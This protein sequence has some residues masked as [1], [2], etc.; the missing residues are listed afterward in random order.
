MTADEA[1]PDPS[2]DLINGHALREN[3][4]LDRSA[5]LLR[6]RH[7]TRQ[8]ARRGG[9]D[10]EAESHERDGEGA[11]H[12]AHQR[13]ADREPWTKCDSHFFR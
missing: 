12:D 8:R 3:G 2:E 7:K 6:T 9:E 11:G 4:G 5:N 10:D 1:N 13:G